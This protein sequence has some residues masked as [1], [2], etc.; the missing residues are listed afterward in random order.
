MGPPEK[1]YPYRELG[2][3]IPREN[4]P[5]GRVLSEC[6]WVQALEGNID[7]SH[8]SYL[9]RNLNELELEPDDTDKP[10]VPSAHMSTFIRGKNRNPVVEVER[11]WYGFRYA[12]LRT[13]PNG[14]THV[15]LTEYILPWTTR[16]SNLPLSDG[17]QFASMVP[18]DDYTCW[19]GAFGRARR[20]NPQGAVVATTLGRPFDQEY[21]ASIGALS[22]EVQ[23]GGIAP[24]PQRKDND[25][26]LDRERQRTYN[27]TGIIGT[28]Q[29]DMAVTESMGE[30]YD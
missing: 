30:I 20:P 14:F 15:R 1:M 9:H 29:Q 25:Y 6:N 22:D 3:A 16:V 4:W 7:T 8:I 12:G 21:L 19:R 10:G 13:T 17:Y 27:Y 18:R 2:P 26:L 5:I 28:G 24:R 11:T 23:K